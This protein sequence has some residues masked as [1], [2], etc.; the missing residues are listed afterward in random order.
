MNRR[1]L[2]V[3]LIA[4]AST[5]LAFATPVQAAVE[6]AGSSF[7]GPMDLVKSITSGNGSSGVPEEETVEP[8]EPKE[9]SDFEL[10]ADVLGAVV[11]VVAVIAQ[12]AAFVLPFIPNGE[13]QLGDFLRSLG[14]KV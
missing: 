14:I 5:T 9:L 8:E 1:R 10:S 7:M 11:G 3:A 4:A 6:P 2:S 13:K 12:S